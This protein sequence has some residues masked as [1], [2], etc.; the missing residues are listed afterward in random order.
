MERVWCADGPFDLHRTL[1]LLRHASSDPTHRTTPDGAL[2]RTSRTPDGPASYRLVQRRDQVTAEAWGP[3]AGWVL[4]GLPELLGSHH[5]LTTGHP[6]LERTARMHPG[7]RIPRTRR[8]FESMVPAILEQKV[9]GQ[10]ARQAYVWL[11]RR[12]AEPAPGPVPTGMRVPPAPEV[13]GRIPSWDWHRA[14]V[15]PRRTRTVLT[16]AKHASRLEEATALGREDAIR[17]L[18]AVPGVGEWTA[19]EVAVRALGDADAVSV[20]DYHLAALVGWVLT[21]RPV[22][23]AGMVELLEPWRP[24]RARVVRLIELSGIPKPRFGPR[25]TVQDHRAH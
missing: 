1:G 2:W 6:V 8:V 25:M 15:D 19:A 20:G 7:I 3:G 23:D 17:R 22:D 14:G 24:H 4:D 18:T 13:W 10:E 5:A 16:A 9:T 12:H 11:L 21:G